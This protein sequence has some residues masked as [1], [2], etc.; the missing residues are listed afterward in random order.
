MEGNGFFI[1]NQEV[2][3]LF[4]QL[5][6][7]S[8]IVLD[9]FHQKTWVVELLLALLIQSPESLKITALLFTLKLFLDLLVS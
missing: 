8:E 5:L 7:V 4:L 1:P 2:H 9:I 6:D 3:Q